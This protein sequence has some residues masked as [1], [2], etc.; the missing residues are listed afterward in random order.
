[1]A[2]VQS[3]LQRQ[4]QQSYFLTSECWWLCFKIGCRWMLTVPARVGPAAEPLV[5]KS[6]SLGPSLA[7]AAQRVRSGLCLGGASLPSVA[8]LTVTSSASPVLTV[9]W[10]NSGC[11]VYALVGPLITLTSN[12]WNN[13][14]VNVIS[15]E[16]ITFAR[17]GTLCIGFTAVFSSPNIVPGTNYWYTW[18]SSS[19]FFKL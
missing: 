12:D 19:K 1:M 17:I 8:A 14:S 6:G 18:I 5:Q 11:L 16:A 9:S 2:A 15:D 4:S 10:T 7:H 13:Y 3:D